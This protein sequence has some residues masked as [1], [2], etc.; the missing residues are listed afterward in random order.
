LKVHTG[1]IDNNA[2]TSLPPRKAFA[3]VRKHLLDMGLVIIK[4]R[5]FKV[6]VMRPQLEQQQDA[7]QSNQFSLY[8]NDLRQDAGGEVIFV[9]ELHAIKNLPQMYMV[10]L[11][12]RKGNLSSYK[13]LYDT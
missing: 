10:A 12:R 7:V 13:Y 2:L 3:E 4:E 5:D 1:P 11:T 8:S 9:V 6:K